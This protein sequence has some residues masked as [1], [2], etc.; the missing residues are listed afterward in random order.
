MDDD[1]PER[2]LPFDAVLKPLLLFF[3]FAGFSIIVGAFYFDEEPLLFYSFLAVASG[4]L[5]IVREL[6]E[7][8]FVW[9]LKTEGLLT[10]AKAVLLSASAVS[11]AFQLPALVLAILLGTATSHLPKHIKKRIWITTGPG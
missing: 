7:E 10:I 5:L 8:G 2:H 3:H 9:F 1:S 11:G 6:Y 4:C